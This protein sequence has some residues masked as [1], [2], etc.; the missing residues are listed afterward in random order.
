M[1]RSGP[2]AFSRHLEAVQRGDADSRRRLWELAYREL[3]T[4]ASDLMRRGSG[5]RRTLQPTALVHEAYLRLLGGERVRVAERAYFFRAAA[6]AMRRIL[7]ERARARRRR[8][9]A[10]SVKLP[11][12]PA[13]DGPHQMQAQTRLDDLVELDDALDALEDAH[14][15]AW[16]VVIH[17]SFGGLGVDETA[18]LL[19]ISPRTADRLWA[20]GRAWLFNRLREVDQASDPQRTR[21]ARASG[22]GDA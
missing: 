15:A 2:D 11:E 16:D 7:I 17:R 1:E 8:A 3:H 12:G 13:S 5:D 18:E 20:F 22:A 21:H 10:G 4:I 9:G 6:L 14:P 19:S